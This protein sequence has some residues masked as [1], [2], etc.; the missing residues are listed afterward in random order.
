MKRKVT[1]FL[2]LAG[3]LLTAGP[4]LAQ[5]DTPMDQWQFG[6]NFVTI[7]N[8][9]FKLDDTHMLAQWCYWNSYDVAPEK[10]VVPS[11]VTYQGNTYTVVDAEGYYYYEQKN[12][13]SLELPAT[14]RRIGDYTFYPFPNI[15][16]FTIPASVEKIGKN[17]LYSDNRTLIFKSV[18]PPE[19]E[20]A[21]YSSNNKI[22]VYVPAAGFEEYYK[23]DYI[24][25]CCVISDDIST[26][27][28]TIDKV[29]DGE[30][31]YLVVG[32]RLPQVTN[33][34]NVN[35]L[36]VKS[37]TIN[38]DDWYQI[39]QMHN[40]I[41]LD[42]EGLS[43]AEITSR[44]LYDCW[45]INTVKLPL[46]L[47]T[48][49]GEAF[50]NSGIKDIILPSSLKNI[51]DG[52]NFRNCDSLRQISIPGGENGVTS[53]PSWCFAY[54]DSLHKVVLPNHLATMG[55]RCF[56]YCDLYD[57]DIPGTLK[58]VSYDGFSHNLH[59]TKIKFNEGTEKLGT[60]AFYGNEML[61]GV[62]FPSTMRV[63]NSYAME[64]CKAMTY[65]NLNEGL[66][67]INSS[68]FANNPGLTEITLPSSLIYC[69]NHPFYN[70]Q[71]INRINC[72][73]LLPPTVKNAIP[74]YEV[75][76]IEVHIPLWSFQ[77]YMTKPGWLEYQNHMVIDPEIL[78]QNIVINK[79]FSFQLDQVQMKEGYHPN[80]RLLWNEDEIDDGFGHTKVERG[81]LTVSS[82][83]K[84]NVDNFSMFVSPYAKYSA[85]YNR[86]YNNRNYTYDSR[87]TKWNPNSLIV[88]GEMRAENQ[89]YHLLLACDV[90]QF[91]SFPFDVNMSDI[92]P[93]NDQTQWVV[94]RYDGKKRADQLFDETWVNLSS[95]DVLE[96]GKGYILK[97]YHND[98]R[99]NAY[100][101]NEPIE[102]TLTPIDNSVN[103]Q[104]LFDSDDR[105]IELADNPSEFEQNRS[106]NLIGN[107]YP[108]YFDS[109][110]LDTDAPFL[111]WD[112]YNG[113]YAA[114]SPVDDDYI[115]NP[116]EAFFIQKP[117]DAN[118]TTLRFLK[119]GRQ[120]YRN[121]NDLTVNDARMMRAPQSADRQV[122]NLVLTQGE[123]SDRTR[124]VFNNDA[125]M[126]YETGRDAAK[127]MAMEANVPQL[128]SQNGN[129]QYAINE[130]PLSTGVVELAVSANGETTIALANDCAVNIMLEDR[131]NGTV[132]PL[133]T[134]G[135]TFQANG[136]TQ[137]RFF[138][139]NAEAT[140]ITSV[141][142]VDNQS[143]LTYNL[144]GQRVSANQRGLLIKQGKK[145]L[146]K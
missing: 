31:G 21:F 141:P 110:Y 6:S 20:G 112:S 1:Q 35:K 25:D 16:E 142:T 3:F 119:G 42:I 135:Y 2:L 50:E 63:V 105:E 32:A 78:P 117:V 140:G 115:L 66:E 33:Y 75:R 74:T 68:S 55:E 134:E 114:F 87:R 36:V 104:K 51:V 113:A 101:N 82:R 60:Y 146:N 77:E 4:A 43:I 84:L 5:Q 41:E 122:V 65:L 116:G 48:I 90:W 109:R 85:D 131:A 22:K 94:R 28:I 108:S 106:W 123:K 58:E 19:V 91:I 8:M 34:A 56:F 93:V 15:H 99:S 46:T 144:Q 18:T 98:Y 67:E 121:P 27:T 79:E 71:N 17:I 24:E 137:G 95:T 86:F 57:I 136:L 49:R 120:T 125:Q 70:C 38:Q 47:E 118:F 62:T 53:L 143:Q 9:R 100:Y 126:N 29:D 132:T 111:V 45:Q 133:T 107:P 44:A 72:M 145:M 83:S 11:T 39:R 130:R 80:M 127:M 10:V 64:Y 97:C 12:T 13:K 102:F 76:N 124:V 14:L 139:V 30:L 26:S 81:N 59:M 40:L 52:N 69:L 23:T 88:K 7:D 138:L 103:R 61:E 37:G 73:S 96:A 89:T 92:K 129:V 128:W 54:C